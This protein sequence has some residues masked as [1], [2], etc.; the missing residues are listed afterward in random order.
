MKVIITEKAKRNL[1]DLFDYN[2]KISLDYALRMDKKIR[3]YIETLQYFQYIGRY[4]PEIPSKQYRERICDKFRII[5]FISEKENT[6]FV[7]YIIATRQNSN[8]LFEVNT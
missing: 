3:A 1:I 7:R 2:A 4:V 6:I 5:Y 8:L